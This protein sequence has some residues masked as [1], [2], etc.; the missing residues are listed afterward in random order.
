MNLDQLPTPVLLVDNARLEANISEMATRLAGVA[1]RP[2]F[3]TSK[4]L[5]VARRQLA[6]G[7]IGF[8][9]ATMAEARALLDAGVPD[10]LWAHPPVGPAKVDFA[11]A[12]A[13]DG[14][15]TVALDSV[16]AAAPLAKAGVRIPY[17]LEID[18]GLGRMGVTP[19]QAV[20]TVAQLAT[21]G[22]LE[23]R[24]V[25][26]QEGHVAAHMG[27]A[28]NAAGRQAGEALVSAATALREAGFACPVVSAGSTPGA[29]S[30]PFVPGVTEA[31][32]GTYIYYDHNQIT[33]G[34]STLDQC[35]LTVLTRVISTQ[36]SDRV[37]VDAGLK[38]MSNDPSATGAGLGVVCSLDMAPLPDIEFSSAHEEH[39]FLTGS[40]I[41][42]LAVGDMLRMVPNHAC[43]TVNMFSQAYSV[44]SERTLESWPIVARH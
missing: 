14:R 24:G 22:P 44:E 2:H 41:S 28:R 31:R 7:A 32:P 12:A 17:F 3:K 16:D 27:E 18:T 40:G 34:T 5:A 37:I 39:G 4:C 20:D 29:D 19:D 35:A 11:V 21:L 23:L 8:T 43:G 13:A 9:C 36:R 10:V 15:L 33:V 1:V 30:S 26:T 42:R 38:A 25:M 6:A